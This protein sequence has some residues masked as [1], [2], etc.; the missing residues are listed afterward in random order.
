[1]SNPKPALIVQ[2]P[3]LKLARI[4]VETYVREHT[5][6]AVPYPLPADQERPQGVFVSIIA[7]K[8]L[9]GSVGTVLPLQP[10]V[11]GEVI[12]NAVAAAVRDPRFSPLRANE[13]SDLDYVIDLI[14]QPEPIAD[15]NQLDPTQYGVLVRAGRKMGVV[16]PQIANVA[17]IE[18]QI[19]LALRKAGIGP[20]DVYR[21]ERFCVQRL[22]NA[23]GNYQPNIT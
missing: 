6:M 7:N 22:I 23:S 2:H 4:A 1:M 12:H 9:R 20:D 17:T 16:L 21:L 13:L 15:Q 14:D 8:Q 5:I 19:A 3:L 11:A 18:S 10:T